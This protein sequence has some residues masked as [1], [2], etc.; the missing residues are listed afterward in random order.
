MSTSSKD[1]YSNSYADESRLHD[2]DIELENYFY[3][4]ENL[5]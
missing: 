3:T 1:D 2:S 5:E 4:N